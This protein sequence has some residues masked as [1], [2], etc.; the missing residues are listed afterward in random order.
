MKSKTE[1]KTGYHVDVDSKSIQWEEFVI[2]DVF[3]NAPNLKNLLLCQ[4]SSYT[5]IG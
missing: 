1:T 3:S 5:D 2:V 4:E